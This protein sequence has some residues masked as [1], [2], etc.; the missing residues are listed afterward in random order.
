MHRVALPALGGTELSGGKTHPQAPFMKSNPL[1]F[2][3]FTALKTTLAAVCITGLALGTAS[4][5][6]TFDY[7]TVGNAGNAADP[8][9][10]SLY[11]SVGY[12]YRIAKTDV[13][14]AQ[15]STFLNAVAATDTYGLYNTNMATNVN[16]AGIVRSGVS[17][18]YTYAVTPGTG[19]HPVTYV[20]MLDA[21]RFANW[22]NNGQK[23]G[24]AGVAST[25]TGA[26]TMSMGGLAPRNA[27]ATVFIPSENEW[28]KAAY[29]DPTPGA[30]GGDN[31]WRYATRSDS[32]PGN[33]IGAGANQANYRE[34]PA[35]DFSVTQ[36]ATYDSTQ[37]Y[38]TDVGAY[39]GSASYYG[40]FDQSG[41]V[42]NWT[43]EII[44]G[45]YRELRGG[46]W[47]DTAG[48]LQ[49]KT[50]GYDIPTNEN[51]GF[52]GFRLASEAL[53]A[54]IPEPTGIVTGILLIGVAALRRRR[55]SAL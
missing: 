22:V 29:Y 52:L 14:L 24:A 16:I 19:Q 20:S 33:N 41:L 27:G 6:L 48:N 26:Y 12:T 4:A 54:P 3:S 2:R 47:A 53:P 42:Y 10:G 23:T 9:T 32:A 43:E 28:Y 18:S 51:N 39:S 13:T 40:T 5:G 21:M 11:G 8:L 44:S 36:I 49:S 34:S 37:N 1:Y 31:Y 25:E 55:P 46:A 30:G 50:R 45:S 35:N 15:Y 17:G 7:A 38:L